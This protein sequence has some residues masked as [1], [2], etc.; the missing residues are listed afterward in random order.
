MGKR[1]GSQRETFASP[2]DFL[3][4]NFPA[5]SLARHF[6]PVLISLSL[7]ERRRIS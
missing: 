5:R 2:P 3:Q 7:G 1:S 4:K 6:V